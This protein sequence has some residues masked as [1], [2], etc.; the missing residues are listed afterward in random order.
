MDSY[1]ANNQRIYLYSHSPDAEKLINSGAA[2][3]SS[4]GLRRPDGTL[5]DMAKPLSFTLDELKEMLGSD[6][7]LALTE[8]R[9]QVLSD[10]IGLSEQ[11]AQELSQIG[12]LN[13]AVIGQIYSMTYAG[14]Q[15]T[16]AGL[17]F[18]SS[19]IN[20][21][22]KRLQQI[23]TNDYKEKTDR[24][25]SNL[26]ADFQKLELPKFDITN[27]SVDEHLND[28]AAFIKR[29]YE[30]FLSG[31]VD[32]F[33]AIRVIQALII[34]FSALATKYSILFFYEN[35]VSSGSCSEWFSL[36]SAITSDQRF[37]EKLQYYIQL[38][39]ELP[40]R[41]KVKLAKECARRISLI[42]KNI[43]FDVEYSLY[44]TKEEYLNRGKKIQELIASTE[45]IPE[46]GRLY[47]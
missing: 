38:E 33:L 13:N 16:L 26:K 29:L 43:A 41:D 30:G 34:P 6:E 46:D 15:Q 11:S 20:E 19:N 37:T 8:Q 24:F 23:E 4:G 12:W 32:G 5:L 18:I 31:S 35:G 36:I 2:T 21:I 3:I 40:F 42:E 28:I 14:F 22:G 1:K 27:S 9:L 25:V 45:A 44:H 47:L 7:R 17:E 39:T 10:R